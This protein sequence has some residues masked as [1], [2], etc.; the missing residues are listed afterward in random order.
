MWTNRKRKGFLTITLH[1]C[2]RDFELK[3]HTLEVLE[4]QGQHSGDNIGKE[5][6]D[7]LFKKYGL[8]EKDLTLIVRDSGSNIVKACREN[9]W[10]SE[11]CFGHQLHLLV[12]PLLLAEKKKANG[13]KNK[14]KKAW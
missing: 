3:D 12:G 9:G 14:K 10:A 11:D 2:T 13:A 4:F 8:D 6:K 5:M 7:I 1:H